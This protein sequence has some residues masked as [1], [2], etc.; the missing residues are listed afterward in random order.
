M[1]LSI[2]QRLAAMFAVTALTVFAVIG[3]ALHGF[4]KRELERHQVAELTTLFEVNEVLIKKARG[5][6]G[7][8]YL[9]GRFD[10]VAPGSGRTRFFVYSDDSR[11]CYGSRP[12]RDLLARAPDGLGELMVDDIPYAMRTL[13]GT[14]PGSPKRPRVRFMV[15]IDST[16]SVQTLR[17]FSVALVTL[18]ITGSLLVALLGHWIARLGLRPLH[19][20]SREAQA[21]SPQKLS[22]RL[23]HSP[24][25]AEMSEL[26]RSFNGALDR[27]ESAY[28]Q[29]QAFNA[30][31]AHE[32]RTPLTNL[33]GQTQV[34]L[35]RPRHGDELQE[36]L[37][38]N[39]EELDRLRGIVNDMLF[40]ARAD[41]GATALDRV[42]VSLAG[43]IATTVEFLEVVLE[44][45]GMQVRVEGD[46]QAGI[47]RALFRRA[48]TNL[49]Q[50]AVEH[51]TDGAE[52]V[53]AITHEERPQE[54]A[55]VRVAV[56]NPGPEIPLNHL[57]RLFDRFYRVDSARSGSG[58][59]HGLG[60]AIV[61]AVATMHGGSVFAMSEKGFT[62]IGFTLI[63]AEAK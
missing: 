46:A 36:V 56:R 30:D 23:D 45:H 28:Q 8:Q 47:E 40:L 9:Q 25:P 20:L 11:F 18:S 53:V 10:A 49:L 29:L 42:Q 34:A 54:A 62:T 12:Q 15:A 50:N 1:N 19:R 5:V 26:I 63:A 7:W 16:P 57:P 2:S 31:V 21:L 17:T 6:E 38:S 60:L 43:E 51:S 33:I 39:L 27:L 14:V 13:T 41:R 24:L 55:Q 32:L 61:K 48:V 35:S 58:E 3:V 37:Q 4:L 59:N 22:Q 52:I 44:E